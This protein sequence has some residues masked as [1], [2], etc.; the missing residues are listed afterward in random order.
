MSASIA[1]TLAGLQMAADRCIW[2]LRQP[3]LEVE[4]RV[5]HVTGA[6]FPWRLLET[7]RR[8]RKGVSLRRMHCFAEADTLQRHLEELALWKA[9]DRALLARRGAAPPERPKRKRDITDPAPGRTTLEGER[10]ALRERIC[11]TT[12]DRILD[13]PLPRRRNRAHSASPATLS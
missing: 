11:R 9:R 3:G 10:R 8:I 13:L 2:L 7:H 6:E 12:A 1:N 5:T 4:L